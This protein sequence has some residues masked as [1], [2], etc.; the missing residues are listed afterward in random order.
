MNADLSCVLQLANKLGIAPRH[1]VYG[2]NYQESSM[3]NFQI[4]RLTYTTLKMALE[5]AQDFCRVERPLIPYDQLMSG[6]HD[7]LRLR[8]RSTRRTRN[9]DN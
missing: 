5:R 3:R 7:L 6:E 2:L 1:I 8:G 9:Y 4:D